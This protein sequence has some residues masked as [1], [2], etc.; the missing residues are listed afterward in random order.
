[1]GAVTGKLILDSDLVRVAEFM[2]REITA[3]RLSFV[4]DRLPALAR[5]IWSEQRC[6]SL[7]RPLTS[8]TLSTASES[9]PV[10]PC[11]DGDSVAVADVPLRT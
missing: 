2:E 6:A 5:L 11:V 7:E 3:D 8:V 4:A 9:G 1:M 10:A